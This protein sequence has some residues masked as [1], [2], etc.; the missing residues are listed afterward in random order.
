MVDPP[1]RQ[2]LIP[3]QQAGRE[4]GQHLLVRLQLIQPGERHPILASHPAQDRLLA[5]FRR[6]GLTQI[7]TG[8]RL[9]QLASGHHP[10]QRLGQGGGGSRGGNHGK[11]GQH[12]SHHRHRFLAHREH[13]AQFLLRP[14]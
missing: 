10:G 4:K 5:G 6:P 2:Q 1:Q 3:E 11:S 7:S 13:R 12:P 9:S 8:V 14:G